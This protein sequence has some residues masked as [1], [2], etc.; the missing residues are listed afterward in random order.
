MNTIEL[1]P[2]LLSILEYSWFLVEKYQD[3][4]IRLFFSKNA[5]G[6]YKK[7]HIHFAIEKLIYRA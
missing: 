5:E 1:T 7:D 6:I 2:F 3:Y 4:Y